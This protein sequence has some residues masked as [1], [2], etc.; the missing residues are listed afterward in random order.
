MAY[1]RTNH[2]LLHRAISIGVGDLTSSKF[3]GLR[4]LREK[5]IEAARA[6]VNL[7][8][9]DEPL[10]DVTCIQIYVCRCERNKEHPA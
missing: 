5:Y 7:V 8:W 9:L 3:L 10:A 6:M 2:N 1:G 4:I